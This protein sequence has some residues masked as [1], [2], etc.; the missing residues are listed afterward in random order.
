MTGC[1]LQHL[2][3]VVV[4]DR[5]GSAVFCKTRD[6]L[7]GLSNMAAGFPLRVA[8]LDVRTPEAL[9]QA[10][11][12]PHLPEVQREILD[13]KSPMAAKMVAKRSRAHTRPGWEEGLRVVIMLW[14]LR[15]KLAQHTAA[16]GG[17]LAETGARPIVEESRLDDFWG[18]TSSGDQLCG[19]NVLGKL[20]EVLR[21]K[22][23]DPAIRSAPDLTQQVGDML[24]CGSPAIPG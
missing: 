2:G 19:R 24:L 8:G 1:D 22:L 20:H 23:G 11:R 21:A 7:G 10:L 3:Q 13:Q 5:A 18:A 17:L 15:V 16:Y 4:Y 9:Y 14:T 6:P 12:Y